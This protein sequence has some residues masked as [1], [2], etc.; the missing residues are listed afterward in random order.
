MRG[1]LAVA[2]VVCL[3]VA[4]GL[5]G[6][7][8]VSATAPPVA[9]GFIASSTSWTSAQ[10]GW[11]LGFEPCPD[12]R[13]PALV[14]TVD[15]GRT[16]RRSAVPDVRMPEDNRRVRVH[17]ANDRVGVIT[18]GTDLYV[19]RTWGLFWR[20][21]EFAGAG[22]S[23]VVG[24]LAD[25]GRS[26]FA[27]VASDT[28]T[29]LFTSRLGR[30]QAVPGVTLPGRATGD[31]VAEGR[32]ADVALTAVHRSHGHWTRA[33]GG[34]WRGVEPP[35]PVSAD[36]DLGLAEGMVFALCSRNPGMG[37]IEKRVERR[38]STGG[39]E[40]VGRAPDLGITTGFA[41]ASPSVLVVSATG[42]GAGLV[43]RSV[44]G[45]QTWATPLV[46][47]G[48]PL[49]DLHF[50]DARHGVL[51]WGRPD[52]G[53]STVYRTQDGGATWTPLTFG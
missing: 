5:T 39:F 11:V 7:P 32:N 49:G 37:D 44:D 38:T 26:L 1:P 6:A 22:P 3:A 36:A 30:W 51:L 16:W 29:R 23:P 4:A 42:R 47:P 40:P 10:R 43:H 19:T 48:G 45:G 13:C 24:A 50:T 18:D 33:G 2:L 20:P 12:G 8:N 34:E 28:G 53:N 15:G 17:F 46:V 31:V 27:V 41:A 9:E 21:V 52:L 35:C 14:R 25:N